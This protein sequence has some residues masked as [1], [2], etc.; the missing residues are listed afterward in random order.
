MDA[1]SYLGRSKDASAKSAGV[2]TPASG[3][4]PCAARGGLGQMQPQGVPRWAPQ[5]GAVPRTKSKRAEILRALLRG[6]EADQEEKRAFLVSRTTGQTESEAFIPEVTFVAEAAERD[7]ADSRCRRVG[8]QYP[9][10]L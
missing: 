3:V 7:C 5:G 6:A 8:N 1:S 10:A 4:P 2:C 9:F